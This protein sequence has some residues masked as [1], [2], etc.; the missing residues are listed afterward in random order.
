MK[1]KNIIKQIVWAMLLPAAALLVSCDNESYIKFDL[2]NSGIYFT[3]DTLN[4]SFSVT[5]LDVKEYTYNIPVQIL[6]GLSKEKRHIG[7]YIDPELTEAEEGVHYSIGEAYIEPGS[8]EG[9]IPV[10][11]YRDKL[12]GTYKTGYKKY[13]LCLR[14]V[15]N[16]YFMPTLD[17]LHQVRMFSFDNSVSQPDWYNAHGE[18]VWQEKYLGKWHPLKFIKMVE[19]FHAIEI[20]QPET[21]KKM[22]ALYGENLE[23]I[24]NGDPFEYRTI[25][26]KYIYSPMYEYFS[27]PANENEIIK[28]FDD[29][30]AEGY[31]DMPDPYSV[32]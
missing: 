10:T 1:Q 31:N 30:F 28:D 26:I 29:F 19:Y 15:K 4:Y 17:S 18:K 16:D 2:S 24:E 3:K 13:K 27:N 14:L 5:P 8:I 25:F 9:V 11:V 32:K 21:Y 23:H 7:Y 6:G 12:E 22:V 20:K